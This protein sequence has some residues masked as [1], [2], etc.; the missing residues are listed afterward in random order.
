MAPIPDWLRAIVSSFRVSVEKLSLPH[1][2]A[3]VPRR[4]RIHVPTVLQME[5]VECGAAALA[6]VLA[7]F[8]R[9]VPLEDLRVACGVSRDGSKAANMLKGARQYGLAARGLRREPNDLQR[10]PLPMIVHWNFNHFVVL[11][12]FRRDR[13]FLNDPAAGPRVVS[14]EEFDRAFTGVVLTFERGAD[15]KRGGARRRLVPALRQRLAGSYAA[16]GYVL[17]TGLLLVVPGLII[18]TFSR[19]FVDDVLVRRAAELAR[20]LF[21]AMGVTLAA[22]A[23]LTW[24]QQ[25]YLLRLETKFAVTTSSQFLWH[26]MHLPMQF[27]S[28]RYPGDIGSRV[29][30]NDRIAYLLSGELAAAFISASMA[31]FYAALMWRYDRVL[32]LVALTTAVLNVIALKYF[33]AKRVHL[34]QQ[35]LHEQARM[36]GTAMSGLQSIETLKAMGAESDLFTKWSGYQAKAVGAEQ[37]LKLQTELLSTVPRLLMPISTAC[38]LGIGGLRVMDGGISMGMLIAF[39]ALMLGF[40]T[41]INRMVDLG[42]TLQEVKGDVA[43]LDDVLSATTELHP[44]DDDSITPP[45]P[46]ASGQQPLHPTPLDSQ[47]KLSGYLELRDVS[48]GYSPLERPLVERFNLVLQ[49]GQR[50][51][52]VGGS[53]CGKTTIARLV[54]GLYEPWTGDVLF[55]DRPRRTIP[56]R[57]M[58]T[59]FSVVDQDVFLFEGSIR[60]NLTLWDS[61]IAEADMVRAAADACMHEEISARP[62]HYNGPVEEAGRNFSGGQKQRLE[63]A[64][65]LV[66]NPTVLVLD[67]ATSALDPT[68]EARID[69]NL[70]RRGCTCL[71]VAHRLSTIRDCDEIIVLDRGAIAQRGTHD[72]LME[73]DGL[74]SRLIAAA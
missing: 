61:T 73:A 11:E 15:F 64:R 26:V 42:S 54:C 63:I 50:V 6:M 41:P 17:G 43:R 37:R 19:L 56:R 16:L 67:E 47:V 71:I 23:T 69:D 46:S 55:D 39:Q 24:L 9:Y 35:L 52:L 45:E 53:G 38:I 33:S 10:L 8:G 49:P 4:R 60:D 44:M 48:F 57:L 3:T 14:A 5:A 1:L 65:A 2:R 27:F 20:P 25:R 58:T 72:E 68:T 36:L 40:I 22:T 7:W 13:V 29:A 59:S 66:T 34:N 21:L 18:P 12:G 70:R 51:A 74:Y 62:D 32:S 31:V 28:Q 30:I